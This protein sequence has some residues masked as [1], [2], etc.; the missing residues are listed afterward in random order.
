MKYCASDHQCLLPSGRRAAGVTHIGRHT[1]RDV[2]TRN[3]SDLDH[4][5]A[6]AHLLSQWHSAWCH[7]AIWARV[8]RCC[9]ARVGRLEEIH[10]VQ[11]A[12][13]SA[14]FFTSLRFTHGRCFADG[15]V[16]SVDFNTTE[17]SPRKRKGWKK[18]REGAVTTRF[19]RTSSDASSIDCSPQYG[20][21]EV[22]RPVG[23]A[24]DLDA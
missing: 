20:R 2:S 16:R 18:G 21:F 3:D 8:A 22:A 24:K 12:L 4:N 10:V 5:S 11:A 7:L 1:S 15:R 13:W 19:C 9:I 23:G 17:P 6:C 14:F